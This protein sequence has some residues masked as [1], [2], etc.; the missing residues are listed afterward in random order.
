MRMG[1][2]FCD[3]GMF[4]VCVLLLLVKLCDDDKFIIF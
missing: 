3:I 2:K 1:M 4:R